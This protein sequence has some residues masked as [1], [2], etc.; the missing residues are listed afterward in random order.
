M[1]NVTLKASPLIKASVK[2]L[3]LNRGRGRRGIWKIV[4]ISGKILAMPLTNL[5]FATW[6]LHCS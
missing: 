2:D 1:Y 5:I 3:G 4:R 6:N